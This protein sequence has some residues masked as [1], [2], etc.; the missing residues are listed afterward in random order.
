[1]LAPI[2]ANTR[3]WPGS[4]AARVLLLISVARSPS[5]LVHTSLRGSLTS[6]SRSR[7]RSSCSWSVQT[8]RATSASSATPAGPTCPMPSRAVTSF[9]KS[10][11]VVVERRSRT[12][13]TGGRCLDH[14]MQHKCPLCRERFS[15]RDVRKLHV[16]RDP[17]TGG[18]AGDPPSEQPVVVAPQIDNASQRLL[19]DIAR[20]VKEGGKVNEIRRVIDECRS[21]YKSLPGNQV[22]VS[23]GVCAVNERSQRVL[24]LVY[25]RQGQ[26]PLAT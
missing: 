22:R 10:E 18:G 24:S 11:F 13:T 25:P 6:P 4:H 1:V 23:R 8:R 21:Y 17:A 7:S 26:L 14:L 16:D 19:D 15:P 20:I 2:Q 3:S 12:Q 9:V 5:G